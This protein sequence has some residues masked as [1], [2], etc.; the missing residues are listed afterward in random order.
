[1]SKKILI[2]YGSRFGST[3]EIS[4]H[5]KQTLEERGFNVELINLKTKHQKVP[6]INN[7]SG[8]LIG[9]GI[10]IGRWTK[11]AKNFLKAHIPEINENRAR[12]IVGI[13]LSSG[14][15]S[16]PEERPGAVEKYLVKVFREL[17]LDLGGHILFDAFGGV[18]DLTES[19]NLG[20]LNKRMLRMAAKEDPNI[21]PD[22]RNDW[23]DWEQINAFLENFITKIQ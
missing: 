13:Y 3:E 22:G 9:S 14:E 18:F 6:T 16:K 1:M 5:F 12:T 11:E 17:G 7:Y 8:V 4:T 21:D 10:R 19:S 20:R 23:R 2:A 15:A